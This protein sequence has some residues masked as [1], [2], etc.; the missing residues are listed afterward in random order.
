MQ[1][2][3]SFVILIVNSARLY[4]NVGLVLLDTIFF[5]IILVKY[6]QVSAFLVILGFLAYFVRILLFILRTRWVNAVITGFK[7][8]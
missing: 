4:P 7:I 2:T 3:V 8:V 1:P 6:A 5:Q